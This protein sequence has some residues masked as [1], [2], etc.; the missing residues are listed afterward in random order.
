M[1]FRLHLMMLKAFD[2][3]CVVTRWLPEYKRF[4]CRP[5]DNADKRYSPEGMY[6][7]N[8]L[9]AQCDFR[10]FDGRP[11]SLGYTLDLGHTL[12]SSVYDDHVLP[13]IGLSWNSILRN[14]E[15]EQRIICGTFRI[16]ISA[17]YTLFEFRIPQSAFR[18]IH[19][20]SI[21]QLVLGKMHLSGASVRHSLPTSF[22]ST[23][24][25]V[26]RVNYL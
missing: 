24:A 10:E 25:S 14:A 3:C 2:T 16:K 26:P 18:K 17:N 13:C 12:L 11:I 21:R 20:P 6:Y 19:R 7:S 5:I 22:T 9:A 8:K 4:N 23:A 15:F 1:L